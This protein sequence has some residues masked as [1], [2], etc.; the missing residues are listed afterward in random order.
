MS[1]AINDLNGIAAAYTWAVIDIALV[2]Q[3][4]R[5]IRKRRFSSSRKAAAAAGLSAFTVAKVENLK[6]WPSYDPGIGIVLKLLDA[7]KTPIGEFASQLQT[8]DDKFLQAPIPATPLQTAA[9]VAQDGIASGSTSPVVE[10]DETLPALRS[11]S[12]RFGEAA[13]YLATR[14]RELQDEVD[15]LK[16]QA[17]AAHHRQVAGTDAAAAQQRAHHRKRARRTPKRTSPRR[18]ARHK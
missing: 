6:S 16:A 15:D 9:A 18:P 4:L 10:H 5:V 8:A 3:C 11:A 1:N 14:I 17:G 7:Y 12:E 2:R 13:E